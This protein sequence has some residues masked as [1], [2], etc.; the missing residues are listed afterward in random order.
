MRTLIRIVLLTVA[1]VVVLAARPAAAQNYYSFPPS[2]RYP[3]APYYV[4]GFPAVGNPCSNQVSIYP[5]SALSGPLTQPNTANPDGSS[6]FWL[7]PSVNHIVVEVQGPSPATFDA[8]LGGGS[9][10]LGPG[11]SNNLIKYTG[12]TTGGNSLFTD[13]GT[14]GA[15]TGTSFTVPGTLNI[16]AFGGAAGGLNL[17]PSSGTIPY[18]GI[19]Q[20]DELI[21][22]DGSSSQ[23]ND[24]LQLGPYV[25]GSGGIGSSIDT[26]GTALT[27]P[28]TSVIFDCTD[29]TGCP[30][31]NPDLPLIGALFSSSNPAAAY[32]FKIN[33]TDELT[34]TSSGLT[35]T[36][37]ATIAG[38]RPWIDPTAPAYGADPTGAADSSAAFN[39]AF[40]ACNGGTVIIPPGTYKQAAQIN[41]TTACNVVASHFGATTIQKAY[42]ASAGLP[43]PSGSW[44]ISASNVTISGII[45]DGNQPGGFT[46]PCFNA[47]GQA[48]QI[49]NVRLQ[50]NFI[51]NC[52]TAG[53][54]FT[55]STSYTN[56]GPVQSQILDNTI[57]CPNSAN[58]LGGII[59]QGE[60]H[61]VLVR[62]NLIDC[63][64]ST[65]AAGP[66]AIQFE[67]QGLTTTIAQLTIDENH[68]IC[69]PVWCIQ[70]GAFNAYVPFGII[71]SNNEMSLG[72]NS[73]GGCLSVLEA[74]SV[75][76]SGNTCNA[77]GFQ[78]SYTGFEIIGD[79]GLISNNTLNW[80][81]AGNSAGITILLSNNSTVSNNII[82]GFGENGTGS[83]ND[84]GI[85]ISGN[86]LQQSISS[87]SETGNIVTV[88]LNTPCP[89]A[90][91]GANNMC[92]WYQP[93]LTMNLQGALITGYNIAGPILN[94]G[95]SR[96][97][98]TFTMYNPTSGLSSCSSTCTALAISSFTGTSGTLTFTTATQSPALVA[99][100]TVVLTGFTAPNTALNGQQVVVLAAGLTTT[101]FE[102]TVTGS[103][104]SSGTGSIAAFVNTQS[105]NNIVSNNNITMPCQGTLA[106]NREGLEIRTTSNSSESASNN[107]L[108]V[109]T[110]VGCGNGAAGDIGF[111]ITGNGT[112]TNTGLFNNTFI[113][114]ATGFSINTGNGTKLINNTYN[115]VATPYN[116][117]GGTLAA[118]QGNGFSVSFSQLATCSA[119]LEGNL[120]SVGNDAAVTTTWGTTITNGGANHVLGQCNGAGA[121]WTMVGK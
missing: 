69:A 45:Y 102:A 87:L 83:T 26:F 79:K 7:S 40:A 54:I 97:G 15:Y 17:V 20:G 61:Y 22:N 57:L 85:N 42:N 117:V 109:N 56:P 70:G 75:V 113:N 93:G 9:G 84:A 104:F 80:E 23:L 48:S 115:N 11:T 120:A 37:N 30:G 100:Q 21:I 34:I 5:T 14:T 110:V 101:T 12:T 67:S 33:T 119:T 106:G 1:L 13:N 38:P 92:P 28:Y 99:G 65:S 116:Y 108:E 88:T 3:S 114:L 64:L 68:L 19:P 55:S 58:T 51:K 77:N 105:S 41:N 46:G 59:I 96:T 53:I 63:H 111:L 86:H 16:P 74:V 82:N 107:T 10:S 50:N 71:I 25:A 60:S 98:A 35:A 103:G 94:S 36:A 78:S 43:G 95:Y 49:Q 29:I 8:I 121:A 27:G 81:N 47:S 73:N 4:C 18:L 52:D 91:Q 24:R 44:L 39:A 90:G 112:F 31:I 66:A 118:A 62:G 32:K 2:Q 6:A 72:I 89:A 76:I